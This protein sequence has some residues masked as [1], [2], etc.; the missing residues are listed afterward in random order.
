ME[1]AILMGL[2]RGVALGL[3]ALLALG[4]WLG[5][6]GS[7]WQGGAAIVVAAYGLRWVFTWPGWLRE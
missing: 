3:F 2:L 1:R 6:S 7:H 4:G 5:F